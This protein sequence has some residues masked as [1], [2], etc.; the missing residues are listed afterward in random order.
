MIGAAVSDFQ[1]LIVRRLQGR[2]DA[3]AMSAASIRVERQGEVLLDWAGGHSD[4]KTGSTAASTESIYHI[5]S[6]SKPMSTTGVAKLIEQGLIDPDDLVVKYVPE[7]GSHGK[8]R[9][10]LRHCFTHTSGLPDMVPGNIELRKRNAPIEEFITAACEARLHF[11]PGTDIRYQSAGILMLGEVAQRVTGK[12][13]REYMTEV[14]FGPVGMNSTHLGWKEEFNNRRIESKERDAEH[15]AHWNHNSPYW[16]DFGGP[17][18]GVH[19]TPADIASLLQMMLDRGKARS[20]NDVLGPGTV[21]LLLSDHTSG[22][23]DLSGPARLREGWGFGW[24]IQ[25]LGEAGWYGSA[26]P[27]GSFG[28]AGGDGTV[29]WA[30]PVSGVVFV[31]LT[32]GQLDDELDALRACGNI[33]A[34]ALCG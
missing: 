31:L 30:D 4:F 21:R 1:D 29:A 20:G 18:A 7:F 8:D 33:T 25:R 17:W 2:I 6:I 34:A 19:S 12:P 9:I 5:A 22:L 23:P 15:T 28:H 14:L 24:R 32:N 11:T 13:F 16:R 3:G 27:A 10:T 26:V